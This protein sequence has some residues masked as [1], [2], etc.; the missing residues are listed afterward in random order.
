MYVHTKGCKFMSKEL[1]ESRLLAPS[2]R[3]RVIAQFIA[4]KFT[5][6]SITMMA[7]QKM[8]LQLRLWEFE[9]QAPCDLH[10]SSR[11]CAVR[12]VARAATRWCWTR[13]RS[14]TPARSSWTSRRRGTTTSCRRGSTGSPPAPRRSTSSRGSSFPPFS[15]SSTSATGATTSCKRP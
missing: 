9:Y 10:C 5:L 8:E 13:A 6:L 7:V 15:P 12:A 4:H 14:C 2:G 1:R 3:R 11:S